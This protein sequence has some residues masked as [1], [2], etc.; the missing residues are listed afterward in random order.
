MNLKD[1]K[2]A[3]LRSKAAELLAGGA[4]EVFIGHERGTLPLSAAPLVI[5]ASDPRAREKTDALVFDRSCG[6]NLANYLHKFKGKRVGLVVKGCDS[7]SVAGLVQERQVR[8]EDLV[9]LG[10]PCDGV[11]DRARVFAAAGG[12]E[13]VKDAVVEGAEVVVAL[14]GGGVMRL[15]LSDMIHRSCRACAMRNP[16]SA[17]FLIAEPVPQ[18]ETPE[19]DPEVEKLQTAA[20]EERRAR[21]DAEMAKCILCY[22]CRNLCPACYCKRCFADATKPG[23][24]LRSDDPADAK[25]YH[26]VRLL[27]LGGRCTGC[28]ACARG[29]PQGVDLMLYNNHLRDVVKREYGFVAGADDNA[30]PPLAQFA[31]GDNNDFIM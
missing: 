22:A 18:P 17:D 20:P 10:A 23:V 13:R 26:F 29:C 25:L 3:D 16:V 31:P 2:R 1:I 24:M 12:A 27:H 6:N 7:R 19:L 11:L 5:H 9:L 4:I 14:E 15:P 8:R 30:Q 21:F 28:G